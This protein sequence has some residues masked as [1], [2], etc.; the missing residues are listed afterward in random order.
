MME[1]LPEP[2][3]NEAIANDASL[4]MPM[5]PDNCECNKCGEK[6]QVAN[7]K[8]LNSKKNKVEKSNYNLHLLKY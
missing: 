6:N 7:I 8:L 5:I 2:Q 3:V 4:H 1:T